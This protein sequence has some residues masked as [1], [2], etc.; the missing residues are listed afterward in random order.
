MG[1]GHAC[2]AGMD[3]VGRGALAGPV[4]VGAVLVTT[5]TPAPPAG[6]R[7]SKLLPPA[8]RQAL[9]PALRAW[10]LRWGVG[11]AWP[12]EIDDLGIIGALGLAGQR[13]LAE[14]GALAPGSRADAVLLDGAHDYLT[15]AL[16][17]RAQGSTLPSVV[18][19]VRGDVACASV[20]AASVLA[21][22]CRDAL[23]V[24]LASQHPGYG[25]GSNKG[26]GA[27]VHLAALAER[28][29]CEEHRLSWSLP[30]RPPAPVGRPPVHDGPR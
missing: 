25:W 23:M 12:R 16:S 29:P 14:A 21:K 7:D 9:V 4:T 2:V 27:P 8:A 28:G 26:Y 5:A 11:H 30:G 17:G 19:R 13:A 15:A 18:T 3:E 20:A 10:A 22:V 1:L 6:L 24:D